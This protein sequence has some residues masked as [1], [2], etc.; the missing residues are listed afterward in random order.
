MQYPG[1]FEDANPKQLHSVCRGIMMIGW[2]M[3][4]HGRCV[5]DISPVSR[6]LL[7]VHCRY[8]SAPAHAAQGGSAGGHRD[9]RQC[10]VQGPD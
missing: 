9:P 5:T 1:L 4:L 6:D 2:I 8:P 3:S 7:P 10:G